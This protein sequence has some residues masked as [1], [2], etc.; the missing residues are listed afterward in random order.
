M[1]NQLMY[2]VLITDEK[3]DALYTTK[4]SEY[5]IS[6]IKQLIN[7]IDTNYVMIIKGNPSMKNHYIKF[8]KKGKLFVICSDLPKKIIYQRI[9]QNQLLI[10]YLP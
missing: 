6:Y 1:E 7:S 8:S 2:T 10:Y 5:V 9:H 4:S 3:C